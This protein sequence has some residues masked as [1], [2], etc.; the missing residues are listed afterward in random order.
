MIVFIEN[1]ENEKKIRFRLYGEPFRSQYEQTGVFPPPTE[2]FRYEDCAKWSRCR[3]E[4]I[5]Y[6]RDMHLKKAIT[7]PE[8][9]APLPPTTQALPPSMQTTQKRKAEEPV[10]QTIAK[11]A[12]KEPPKPLEQPSKPANSS[13]PPPTAETTRPPTP[14]QP[15]A[16]PPEKSRPTP[17]I[18]A[19]PIPPTPEKSASPKL[20]EKPKSPPE[21]PPTPIVSSPPH[22]TVVKDSIA[23]PP[24]PKKPS[25]PVTLAPEK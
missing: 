18:P 11:N 17:E 22:D 15:P 6:F 12:R 8:R 19:T 13:L 21:K 14:A 3:A 10:D 1:S 25:S 2:E 7:M 4:N 20:S 23:P 5:V 16:P 24:A 9:P